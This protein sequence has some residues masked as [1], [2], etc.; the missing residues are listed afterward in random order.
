MRQQDRRPRRIA[1]RTTKIGSRQGAEYRWNLTPLKI[2]GTEPQEG[3]VSG[4]R[5]Q[6]V[7]TPCDFLDERPSVAEQD[8]PTVLP[9]GRTDQ[10]HLDAAGHDVRDRRLRPTRVRKPKRLRR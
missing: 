4:L 9:F 8:A 1:A 10:R 5:A 7:P 3:R 2:S 6:E